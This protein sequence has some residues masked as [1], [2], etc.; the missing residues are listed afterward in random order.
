MKFV[1]PYGFKSK[2]GMK[3]SEFTDPR[4]GKVYKT[5]IIN[6]VE[7]FRENL[8]YDVIEDYGGHDFVKI[9][10]N[11][12]PAFN[13]STKESN[14][15]T[16]YTFDSAKM[17]CPEGWTIP[18]RSVFIDLFKSVTN[19][20]PNE[21]RESDRV[22][23][24]HALNPILGFK[25]CGKFDFKQYGPREMQLMEESERS[26]YLTSTPGSMSNGGAIFQFRKGTTD[27][28][29]DVGYGYYPVRPVR[30]NI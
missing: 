23:I 7:W 16:F 8:N 10:Y 27:Y 17:A 14:C 28:A 20:P 24:Y 9:F 15:G 5:V 6:G 18:E 2:L 3:T 25:F 13:P 4:D 22:K 30:K 19:L 26:Y 21:W 1:D 29:E 11:R 12:F